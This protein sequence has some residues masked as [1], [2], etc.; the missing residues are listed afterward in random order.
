MFDLDR[1]IVGFDRGLRTL[2][3]PPQAR[4]AEPGADLPEADL[5]PAER[6]LAAALMRVNH[7]GEV[8][9]Q[10]LYQGQML[11]ARDPAVRQV[12]EQAAEEETDHLAW[13]RSRIDA[14]GG[15]RSHLDPLFYAGAFAMGALSGLAGDRWNLGFLSETERQVEGHLAGH[16][17]R[18]PE[19]DAKSRAVVERMREDESTHA[20]TAMESGGA[21]LPYPVR[22]AMKLT[23]RVMTGTTYY[24]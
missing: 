17:D 10:A 16:L 3:V 14:L 6:D 5:A 12:L 2:F 11:T 7:T 13:T 9:A 21:E 4:R 15:R 8:C 22:S 24:V 18:L 1:L 20:R 19:A 23:S